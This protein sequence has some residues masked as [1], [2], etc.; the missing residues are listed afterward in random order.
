V[1]QG[2]AADAIRKYL[3]VEDYLDSSRTI[4]EALR[5]ATTVNKALNSGDFHLIHWVTNTIRN[6]RLLEELSLQDPRE[7][8]VIMVNLGADDAE[9]FLGITWSPADVLGFR[10]WLAT[11]VP[12]LASSRKWLYYLTPSAPLSQ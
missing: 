8:S 2:E 11:A 5:R 1:N 12:V 4:D 6:T 7:S 9:M 3:D 10:V